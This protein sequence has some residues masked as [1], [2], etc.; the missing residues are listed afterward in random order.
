MFSFV[1]KT[2]KKR[3]TKTYT[4]LLLYGINHEQI[5]LVISQNITPIHYEILFKSITKSNIFNTFIPIICTSILTCV[6]I[7]L[8]EISIFKKNILDL[9]L[10]G[11]P[12]R[13]RIIANQCPSISINIES[14]IN[15]CLR[16]LNL[17]VILD[18]I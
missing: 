13:T 2:I 12:S 15:L 14:S 10:W 16:V 18:K 17:D 5:L 9:E 8:F 3:I 6:L 4:S 7:R 11:L 1:K